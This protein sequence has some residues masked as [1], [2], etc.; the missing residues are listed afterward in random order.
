MRRPPLTVRFFGSPPVA[1]AVVA[2]AAVA[3]VG[4]YQDHIRI[5]LAIGAVVA[6]WRSL[7]AVT[8]KRRYKAWVADWQ[9]IGAEEEAPRAKK[10]RKY[11]WALITVA[12]L[13]LALVILPLCQPGPE[14]ESWHE[15]VTVTWLATCLLA[16]LVPVVTLVRAVLRRIT[17]RRKARAETQAKTA[18]VAWLVARPSSSPSRAE[19]ERAL[20]EYC[21]RLLEMRHF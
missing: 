4:W 13:L 1:L 5:W 15:A 20:P 3:V 2:V 10:K 16:V 11:G 17:S 6:A 9:A 18:P 21:A 14:R 8:W 7:G 19:V 12:L